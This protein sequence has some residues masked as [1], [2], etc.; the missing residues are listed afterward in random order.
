MGTYV[1]T[2]IKLICGIRN[3]PKSGWKN[4]YFAWLITNAKIY[5]EVGTTF[6]GSNVNTD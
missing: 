4:R 2:D 3:K 1:I 5:L 6:S